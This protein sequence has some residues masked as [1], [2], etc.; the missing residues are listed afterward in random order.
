MTKVRF[1][2]LINRGRAL[3]ADIA[4]SLRIKRFIV[5]ITGVCHPPG[6]M[7][8]TWNLPVSR[9]RKTGFIG[10]NPNQD[11][12][13]NGTFKN[14][15]ILANEAPA[16]HNFGPFPDTNQDYAQPGAHL[17]RN[18][19]RVDGFTSIQKLKSDKLTRS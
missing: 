19:L 16:S 9:N 2:I 6:K 4:L 11:S 15:V 3:F 14:N 7:A 12:Q 1:F 8:V 17:H 10:K 18:S 5:F 13:I